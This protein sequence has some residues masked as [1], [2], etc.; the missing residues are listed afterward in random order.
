MRTKFNGILT[1]LLALIVQ[2][3]FAQDKVISG[4]VSDES[5]P[6][7]GVTVIKKGTTQGTETDF[8]GNYSIKAKTGDVLVFS[9]V[10]MKNAE[11]TVGASNSISIMMETDNLLDEVVVVGYGTTTKQSYTGTAKVVKAEQLQAKSISNVSQ[12]LAGEAAGVTV[13][14]NSGQPGR[15]A[16]IRI[17][18]FGSVNGNRDPLYVVDG[19]PY[20]GNINSINPADIETTTI[21]KDATATAIYGARGAHGVILITT[22]TGKKGQTSIDVDIKTGVNFA[23]LKRHDVIRNPDQY[24]A[25]SWEGLY[26]K[27]VTRGLD[28]VAFANDNLFGGGGIDPKYNYYKTNDVS[29]II[30]PTTRT[31]NSGLERRY[32]PESWEDFSFQTSIRTEANVRFSGGNEN[33]KYYSSFGYLDDQGYIIN[34]DFNRYTTRFNLSHKPTEWL[35]ASANVGYTLSKTNNNGQSTDSGS[36]FWFADNLPSIYPLFLRDADG[37]KINDPFFKGNHEYDYGIGRGFGALTN[38]IADA[39]YDRSRTDRN[40]LNGSFKFDVKLTEDL[41]FETNF[42]F[43]YFNN[44]FYSL[45]NP[46]YG[47]GASNGGSI[48]RANTER[49]VQNYLQLLRYRKEFGDHSLELLAGHESNE[50]RDTRETVSKNKSVLPYNSDLNNFVV[51]SSPPTGRTNSVKLESYFGQINY[52][53]LDKYYLNGSI[54]R[55]GSSRFRNKED[56]WDTFWSVGAS[57]I[58]SK[59]DFMSDSVFEF[60]KFKT[61]YG[62]TGD[63]SGV[64]F[65]P[66]YDLYN[67]INLNDQVGLEP[68]SFANPNLTWEVSKMFQTGFE[69][70]LGKYLDGSIEYFIKDTENLI[71][72]RRVGPSQGIATVKV[73][74]GELRNTGL[75]FDLTGHLVNNEDFKLDLTVNGAFLNNEITQMPFDPASGE[76]KIIDN[77]NFPFAFGKGRSIYDYYVREWAGVDPADGKSMWYQSFYDANNDGIFN[78]GDELVTQD[79]ENYKKQNPDNRTFGKVTTKNYSDATEKYIGKS[80]V[81]TLRGAFRLNASYKNFNFSTL[82]GY[83]IGGYGIDSHY[84]GLMGNPQIGNNNFSTDILNRWQQ[85]GDITNVPRLSDNEDVRVNSTSS[86][87]II[88]SDYLAL[89]NVR[90]GYTIPKDYLTKTGFSNVNLYVSGDNLLLFSKRQGYNPTLSETGVNSQYDYAPISTF[91]LGVNVKF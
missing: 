18:G 21:L 36:I 62:L 78:A 72:D 30:N 51:V 9:F 3:S 11:K 27:A 88:S 8:D 81:P 20:S 19:V 61:S 34:S 63:Q 77:S 6:L 87:F 12:A 57:W 91:T 35:T 14:A 1:L 74:D 41:T 23:G 85:P 66:S 47:S 37:N 76:R 89:N 31:V 44:R 45:N 55:D 43:Q 73:N 48:F 54:R 79:L 75:E 60:L 56:R 38:A 58:I 67:I 50:Y 17:R 52:N 68:A 84:Q 80:A 46:Y 71:F 16:T 65:Y 5:G 83:S 13:I 15:S 24:L 64:G 82:W 70:T 7:P 69:F 26:N 39:H 10:G 28:P 32:T 33:T 29:Q 49:F 86:R 40:E 2:I 25:L 4:T 42:G 59:E 22:N 53:Y 90:L